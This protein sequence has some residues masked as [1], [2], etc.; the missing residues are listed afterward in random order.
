[1][2]AF[3][4]KNSIANQ[5]NDL[6]IIMETQDLSKTGIRSKVVQPS[7]YYTPASGILLAT[8]PR[9][10]TLGKGQSPGDIQIER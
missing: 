10:L 1:M 3:L 8:L 2:C 4:P 7:P 5:S 9:K 6:I